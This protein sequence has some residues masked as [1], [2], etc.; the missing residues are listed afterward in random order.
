MSKGGVIAALAAAVWFAA[1]AA[2]TRAVPK[3]AFHPVGH[4][5][6]SDL[7]SGF[8]SGASSVWAADDQQT[9]LFRIDPASN[10]VVA[11]VPIGKPAPFKL[12]A[13][14]DR[15]DDWVTVGDGFVWATDQLH[16]RIVR[17]SP[18]SLRVV[19]TIRVRSPWDIAVSNGAVWVPQFEAYSVARID[20]RSNSV[21][22]SFPAVGPTSVSVGAGSVWVLEHRGYSVLRID[23]K[24][25]AV[26]RVPLRGA[27]GPTQ[28][29]FLV[30]SL[31][32]ADTGGQILRIEPGSNHVSSIKLTGRWWTSNTVLVSDGAS[33]IAVAGM[34]A[35]ARIDPRSDEVIEQ[36]ALSPHPG[37]CGPN[38]G[39][40]CFFTGALYADGTVWVY[41]TIGGAIV[42]YAP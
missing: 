14:D 39:I 28:C 9:R 25:D 6:V 4:I 7:V 24:S 3:A 35:I 18:G 11:T 1:A 32:C 23:P 36:T 27:Q 41:D 19:S 21:V 10:R 42:R 29:R 17:V 33:V 22:K 2:P 20:E 16:D 31:W 34:G 12:I 40:F 15:V 5:D 37:K 38:T 8:A 26:N 30:G 13:A